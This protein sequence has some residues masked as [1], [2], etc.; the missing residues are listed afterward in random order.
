MNKYTELIDDY[1]SGDLSAEEKAE[2][3]GR[4]QNEK[5]LKEEFELQKQV[6]QGIRDAGMRSEIKKGFRKASFKR[7][8]GKFLAGLG[9]TL[10]VFA[11][12]WV[13]QNRS[14]PH[15]QANIR[16][17]LNEENN[18]QWSDADKHLMPEIFIVDA[19]RDTVI[20]TKNGIIFTIPANCF[21]NE[22]NEVV[23]G[24]VELEVKEAMN[25]MDIMRAGLSTVSDDNLLETG[26]MFYINARQG[27]LNLEIAKAKGIYVSIPDRNPGKK[28][29]LF[30]GKRMPNGKIDWVD[31]RPFENKINPVD[32]L[33]LNFYPPHF[34]D[35]LSALGF[36]IKNKNLSDSVYYSFT[37]EGEDDNFQSDWPDE[38]TARSDSTKVGL[39]KRVA[40]TK[41][42]GARLFRKNCSV[43]HTTD[44]RKLTGPGLA[45]MMTRVPGG[46]WLTQYI[47]N[48]QKLIKSGDAY[49]N[50]I[51]NENGKAVMTV[52]E[53]IL[54]ERDVKAIINYIN[55]PG[56]LDRSGSSP[57]EIEP[58]RIRAIWDRKLNNTLLATKEFEER[59]RVIFQNCNHHLL[60]LYV[61]NLDKNM[62]EIDSMAALIMHE[63][64]RETGAQFTNF[65]KR[66]NGRVAI[67]ESHMR[68]LQ[69]YVEEKRN[70]YREA[71]VKALRNLYA[72]EKI[73]DAQALE[74]L[75]KQ[76]A[77]EN[78]RRATVFEEEVKANMNEAYRQLG[79]T[80]DT[81]P[82]VNSNYLGITINN[83]GW[84]NV[85]V[86]VRESATTRTTMDYTD[87]ATGRKA[88][89][90]YGLF[91]VKVNDF[92]KY[93][94]VYTYLIAD[95]LSSFL[96]VPNKG[97]I[98][99]E[100]LNGLFKYSVVVF[101]FS[102]KDIYFTEIKEAGPGQQNVSL[103]KMPDADLER[104]KCLNKVS[105]ADVIRDLKFQ[106][107]DQNET[108]RKQDVAK[109][110]QV[111]NRLWPVVFPCAVEP[112]GPMK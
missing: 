6:L 99:K 53:G 101:G 57:C 89:I 78:N 95:Q 83:T 38:T 107:F 27:G 60:D 56:Q 26:G 42:N 65:Y 45:G 91:S 31:P 47:L 44:S 93:E 24:Q 84:K 23:T 80:G 92:D 41:P 98:F 111:K 106:L 30:D 49:A 61:N 17:E 70:L 76:D 14:I 1:L 15:D 100:N 104:Y 28:M 81:P 102:G 20:E 25:P 108:K 97:N 40:H 16:H 50:K 4:L 51:Y 74:E 7:Q 69:R 58:S 48:S 79:R 43:C 11:S 12:V 68:E 63:D 32:I 86:F 64:E 5:E 36:D 22:K 110:E 2:F 59:L 8:S 73:K 13:I 54:T 72:N 87:T 77:A 55:S 94:R 18:K 29:M 112:Q 71:A 62:F 52:F 37:C 67:D 105:T 75:L 66:K 85:D 109:R 21:L 88:T 3:E 96:R 9:I 10:L 33:S 103:V 90:K 46:P 19:E 82:P 34:L 35:S 39:H